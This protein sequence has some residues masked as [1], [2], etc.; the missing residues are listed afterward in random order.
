MAAP[1]RRRPKGEGGIRFHAGKQ[2]W[3]ATF[4]LGKDETG[5]RHRRTL[6]AKT[7]PGL[8]RTIA[9]LKARSGGAIRRRA[10]GTVGAF[11]EQ[12][13]RDDVKP[14]RAANTYA[15]NESLWRVHAARIVSGVKLE[16]FDVEHVA[17]LYA[18]LRKRGKTPSIIEHV[19]VLMHRVFEVA[20]RRRQYP[21]ANPFDAI[22]RPTCRAADA[23]ALTI[24]QARRFVD[25][26]RADR[27]E[28]LWIL[29][30]TGGLRLGEALALRWSDVDFDR[31]AVGVQRTLLEVGGRVSFGA[32][33][34]SGSRRRVELGSLAREALLRRLAAHDGERHGSELVFCTLTGE[35]MRRSN[36]RRSHFLPVL[37]A[38]AIPR[39]RIHD[40]RHSMTSF[41]VAAG[42]LP[43]V[44]AER[45]GH[46]TTRLTQDRYSHVLPGIDGGAA[47]AIDALLR[48]DH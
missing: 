30:L 27:F 10:K 12:W 16:R 45:L 21:Y 41:G 22:D 47:D 1:R 17:A 48:V 33:K 37:H 11:V 42:V 43:K 35:P 28:A 4:D 44:L 26:A 6:Y 14:N 2:L 46:S 36:L 32:P 31:G 18:E 40:L 15:L 38:A 13:L 9:D 25:A 5:R 24:D 39:L 29:L 8:L 23:K 34:T 19:A 20:V 7:R 3:E